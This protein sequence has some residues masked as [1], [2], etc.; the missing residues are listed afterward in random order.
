M[1]LQKWSSR[2][3]AAKGMR[4]SVVAAHTSVPLAEDSSNKV[5]FP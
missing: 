4:G 5:G 2:C 3:A 1:A